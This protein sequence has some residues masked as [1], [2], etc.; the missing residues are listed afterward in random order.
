MDKKEAIVLLIAS[1]GEIPSLKKLNYDNQ[2]FKL[3]LN[4]VETIIKHGLDEDDYDTFGSVQP[5]DFLDDIGIENIEQS[6]DYPK[7]LKDYET[8]LKS[9]IQKHQ[10]LGIEGKRDKGGE[11]ENKMNKKEVMTFLSEK[12]DELYKLDKLPPDNIEFPTWCKEIEIFLYKSFGKDSVEYETFKEAGIILGIVEDKYTE[13]RKAIKSRETAL[14]AIAKAHEKLEGEKPLGLKDRIELPIQLFDAMQF[15][16]KVVKASKLLFETGNYASAILEAFKAVNIFVKEKSGL[17]K[18][19]LRGIKDRQLMA[20]VFDEK[21]PLIKLNELITDTDFNE[22]EG[23]KLLF[24]GATEGI[25]NPK[26]HDLIEMKDPYRTLEY[27]GFASLLMHKISFW[28]V[29]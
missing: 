21:V 7:K 6:L 18:N 12:I 3:W 2:K 24:M 15:H 14:F 8:A 29:E 26:A 19:A 28:K 5:L 22:Q 23:F 11:V 13:Y 25:R 16:P 9:I 20:K 4:G 27:L 10:I 1:L 17:S